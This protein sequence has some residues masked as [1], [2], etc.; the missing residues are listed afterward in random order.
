MGL[1]GGSAPSTPKSTVGMATNDSGERK[2]PPRSLV[3]AR[4]SP[5]DL[6]AWRSKAAAS[7]VSSSALLRQAMTHT[8]VWTPT[9][10]D[11]ERKRAREVERERTREIARIGNNV[12]QLAKWANRY[13]SAADAVE[14][15]VHLAAIERA[16][17]NLT[18]SRRPAV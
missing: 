14:V 2:P 5:E 17:R 4:V 13:Q 6:A 9:L 10:D 18:P 15:I 16:L 7:G 3:Q 11:A 8:E 1:A 12:N